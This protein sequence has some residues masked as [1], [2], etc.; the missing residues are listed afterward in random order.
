MDCC[1]YINIYHA[2]INSERKVITKHFFICNLE[3][4]SVSRRFLQTF[5]KRLM[6]INT[7]KFQTFIFRYI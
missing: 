5:I 6:G 4:L 7:V 1:I 2:K 3:F